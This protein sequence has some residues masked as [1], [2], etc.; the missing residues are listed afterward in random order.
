MSVLEAGQSFGRYTIINLD[1]SSGPIETYR[2]YD[3]S[4]GRD[5]ALKVLA[6]RDAA[7][8]SRFNA[9]VLALLDLAH[10]SILDI[11]DAGDIDGIHYLAMPLIEGTTLAQRLQQGSLTPAEIT[12]I[13]EQIGGALQYAHEHGIV[14]G[15]VALDKIIIDRSGKAV[16]TDFASGLLPA[17]G[18]ASDG[19]QRDLL[20]LGG[21]MLALLAGHAIDAPDSPVG[22]LL[23]PWLD[24][25]PPAIQS[26]ASDNYTQFVSR[27]ASPDAT[28]RFTSI[29]DFLAAW[30]QLVKPDAVAPATAAS[31]PAPSTASR[32]EQIESRRRAAAA[33]QDQARQAQYDSEWRER[34]ESRTREAADT[35]ARI[36]RG[37]D[38]RASTM[39][40]ARQERDTR[41]GAGTTVAVPAAMAIDPARQ[42][43][44]RR[45]LTVVQAV[46][47][48]RASTIGIRPLTSTP[49]PPKAAPTLARPAIS[50]VTQATVQSAQA[51]VASELKRQSASAFERGRQQAA[52]DVVTVGQRLRPVIATLIVILFVVFCVFPLSC[53]IWVSTLPDPTSTPTRAAPTQAQPPTA[54]AA[55]TAVATATPR[56]ATATPAP[57]ASATPALETVVVLTDTFR[58]GACGLPEGSGSAGS[59]TCA[60]GEYQMAPAAA[61]PML[62]LFDSV[63]GSMLLDV[64]AR[65]IT[66]TSSLEYGLVWAATANHYYAITLKPDGALAVF[67][68]QD[69][70]AQ[71][72]VRGL[73]FSAV[74]V[75]AQT[76]RLRVRANGDTF[77]FA[78]NERDLPLSLTGTAGS[79]GRFGFFV[80]SREPGAVVAF[81]NLVVSEMRTPG[82]TPAPGATVVPTR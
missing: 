42:A 49:A 8:A 7:S 26:A 5:V 40:R 61:E 19:R 38:E 51:T 70:S 15:A 2:A 4:I 60:N 13:V 54:A 24:R 63:R 80:Q 62:A 22:Q 68:Q 9:A 77:G 55:R 10:P 18:S 53:I 11:H 66:G 72:T 57:R 64:N 21:V 33:A 50:R 32:A 65:I 29:A 58:S 39:L 28:Q 31:T 67:T 81:S 43:A 82:G 17:A 73:T 48:K 46:A 35:Q 14:S 52:A 16:L 41:I 76:N 20:M 1:A 74:K 34:Q 37:A 30:R 45:L 56:P 12:R 6:T 36:Q 71:Y 23:K 75:G 25:L 78:I 3:A 47:D 79:S 69:G 27:A 59:Q 44:L